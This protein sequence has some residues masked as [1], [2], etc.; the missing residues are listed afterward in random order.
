MCITLQVLVSDLV[1]TF[2]G[3]R[4][5]TLNVY[6]PCKPLLDNGGGGSAGNRDSLLFLLGFHEITDQ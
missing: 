1:F 6:F 5:K 2:L 4:N 3:E